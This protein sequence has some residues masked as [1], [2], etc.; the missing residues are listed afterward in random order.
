MELAQDHTAAGLDH[1]TLTGSCGRF[2][3]QHPR[4]R[5]A[6]SHGLHTSRL[7]LVSGFWLQPLPRVTCWAQA[8][9]TR[10]TLQPRTGAGI[11]Q[12]C[13]RATG[14]W[15]PGGRAASAQ[16]K[17]HRQ[18]LPRGNRSPWFPELPINSTNEGSNQIIVL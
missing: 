4:A 1:R 9:L 13:R 11:G 6:C 10:Q 18:S 16:G 14:L 17:L 7:E 2:P 3:G 15:K 8:P 12:A 5:G